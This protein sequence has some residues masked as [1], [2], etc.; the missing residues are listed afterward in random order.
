MYFLSCVEI[1]TTTTT[2]KATGSL[3]LSFF[4]QLLAA[5]VFHVVHLIRVLFLLVRERSVEICK[6]ENIAC[7]QDY[8]YSLCLSNF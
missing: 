6:P 1:K 2:S 3:S 8:Q 5:S 7:S 4:F